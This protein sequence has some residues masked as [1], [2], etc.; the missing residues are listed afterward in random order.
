M[1]RIKSLACLLLAAVAPSVL[2]AHK[3][4]TPSKPHPAPHISGSFIDADVKGRL[5]LAYPGK[6][7]VETFTGIIHST[8][9]LPAS[10]KSG[11]TKP[12]DL[13][14]IPLGT[15][16]TVYYV[17]WPLG[18]HTL[19]VIMSIR[20]DRLAS[21]GSTLPEGVYIPCFKGEPSHK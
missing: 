15:R 7:K 18:K 13:S 16:M 20:I 9:M 19:N 12:L 8:C 5:R 6:S 2:V 14:T 17:N 11:E 10:S 1:S 3:A 21:R 4:T